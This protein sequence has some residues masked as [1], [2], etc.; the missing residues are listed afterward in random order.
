MIDNIEAGKRLSILIRELG[1]NSRKFAIS[2]KIDP[3]YISKM[4]KGEKAISKKAM[5]KMHE[6]YDVNLEWLM[7]GKGNLFRSVV[8]QGTAGTQHTAE[9]KTTIPDFKPSV[10]DYFELLK[11]HN[12]QLAHIIDTNLTALQKG[13]NHIMETAD[14]ILAYQKSWVQMVAEIESRGDAKLKEELLDKWDS[15]LFSKSPAAAGTGT[16]FSFGK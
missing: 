11:K 1:M 3:S 13:N 15:I 7:F 5:A 2:L 10:S 12:D 6:L 16:E 9:Q 4:E 14:T 8:P